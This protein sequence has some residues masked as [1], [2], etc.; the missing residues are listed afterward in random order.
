VIEFPI[1]LWVTDRLGNDIKGIGNA[2][3][4]LEFFSDV[5]AAND[6]V[7]IPGAAKPCNVLHLN[8][9]SDSQTDIEQEVPP[10]FTRTELPLKTKDKPEISKN[11]EP[12]V[13][14][15]LNVLIK[16]V[17]SVLK[18][19]SVAEAELRATEIEKLLARDPNSP[20]LHI[21]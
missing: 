18:I 11:S 3:D 10:T 15:T 13:A 19:E 6:T 2:Y 5:D 7:K 9:L 17:F 1:L 20:I 4:K 21:M 16:D 12:V 8:E 14:M